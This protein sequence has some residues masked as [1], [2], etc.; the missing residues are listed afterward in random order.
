M[1]ERPAIFLYETPGLKGAL[2]PMKSPAIR[3]PVVI[4][5]TIY[6]CPGF[7]LVNIS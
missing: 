5:Y 7:I 4:I 2:Y 1:N 3:L 6:F